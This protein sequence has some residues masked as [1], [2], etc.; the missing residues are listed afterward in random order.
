MSAHP[1]L[2][3]TLVGLVGL[4][5]WKMTRAGDTLWIQ[6]GERRPVDGSA[7]SN[8]AGTEGAGHEMGTLALLVACPWRWVADDRILVGSGD[9]LTPADPDAELEDFDWDA[10]GASWLDVRLEELA[11]R[12]AADPPVV[13]TA[14]ADPWLGLRVEL[15][16]ATALELFPNST[17]TGHVSTEFWRLLQP[18]TEAPH[19]VTGTFGVDRESE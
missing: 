5:L 13:R 3:E 4:P 8:G 14:I 11:T 1:N 16:D 17:P 10:A 19:L 15:S 18:G 2:D 9:L 12:L 7:G 6:F